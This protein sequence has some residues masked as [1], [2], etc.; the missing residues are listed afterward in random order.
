MHLVFAFQ[1]IKTFADTVA[2]IKFSFI[3]FVLICRG[4]TRGD[5]VIINS[6]SMKV[7]TMVKKAHLGFVTSLA[8]SH[9]SRLVY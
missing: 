7:Q 1:L 4:T 2:T 8:F 9:D 5:V 6:S 3:S